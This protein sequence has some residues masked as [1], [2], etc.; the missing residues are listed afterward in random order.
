MVLHLPHY[1]GRKNSTAVS[2]ILCLVGLS[3]L[4]L[5]HWWIDVEMV[6]KITV[7]MSSDT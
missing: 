2:S 5:G 1:G 6:R 4:G 7:V 3:I